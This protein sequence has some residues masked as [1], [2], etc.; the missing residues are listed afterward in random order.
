MA[1]YVTMKG[2]APGRYH[3]WHI[4][5]LPHPDISGN[6]ESVEDVQADGDELDRIK[7]HFTNLPMT[8]ARVVRWY[9]DDAKFI[10]GNIFNNM[11][12]D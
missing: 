8:T 11:P 4:G 7:K 9:G 10:A 1:L 3:T 5:S 2:Q 6:E 12:G